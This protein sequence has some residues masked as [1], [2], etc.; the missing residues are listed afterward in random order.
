M[1]INNA[2]ASALLCFLFILT[3]YG[4]DSVDKS[5]KN[6]W[7]VWYLEL[8]IV[9]DLCIDWILI[10]VITENRLVYLF[11]PQSLISYITIA[12]SFFCLLS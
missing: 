9:I 11:A 1:E 5:N 8:L 3:T 7:I 10:L 6:N 12:S 4:I 2:I